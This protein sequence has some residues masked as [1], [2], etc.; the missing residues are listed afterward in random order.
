LSSSHRLFLLSKIA[1]YNE[2][3]YRNLKNLKNSAKTKFSRVTNSQI[4]FI[5][6]CGLAIVKTG[7]GTNKIYKSTF[8]N[9][10]IF[11]K[12]HHSFYI[13]QS[14]DVDAIA[15]LFYMLSKRDRITIIEEVI[16][17]GKLGVSMN[18]LERRMEFPG[19]FSRNIT[20]LT[21]SEIICRKGKKF[22]PGQNMQ[23]AIIILEIL[24]SAITDTSNYLKS[25]VP[26]AKDLF[27]PTQI[28]HSSINATVGYA[29]DYM[30]SRQITHLLFENENGMD[31]AIGK[32]EISESILKGVAK[33]TDRIRKIV[34]DL[35]PIIVAS[36]SKLSINI[37]KKIFQGKVATVIDND[38]KL[39]GVITTNEITNLINFICKFNSHGSGWLTYKPINLIAEKAQVTAIEKSYES[40]NGYDPSFLPGYFIPL[41]TLSKSQKENA[42]MK[43]RVS[44]EDPYELKYQH[45][46]IVMNAKRRM[47]Y[48]AAINIDGSKSIL[49][50]PKPVEFK[51]SAPEIREKWYPD[52]R[53]ELNAQFDKELY[54]NLQHQL[55]DKGQLVPGSYV[56][57]GTP[58]QAKKANVD[59]FHLTNLSLLE[60]FNQVAKIWLGIEDYLLKN[61]GAETMRITVFV[62]PIFKNDD[63]IYRHM[64]IPGLFWKILVQEIEGQLRAIGLMAIHSDRIQTES[65]K[66]SS[67]AVF[68][69]SI[70]ELERIT[71]LDFGSL[72]N[73]DSFQ[74]SFYDNILES[75]S[76]LRHDFS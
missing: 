56:S 68:Q 36:D 51:E 46:S 75:N 73:Y 74:Q 35:D 21:K 37:T 55:V 24:R 23:K 3:D 38:G 53:I 27:V 28:Q 30:T 5:L 40:R 69:V 44:N 39:L 15:D 54:D 70:N 43:T 4:E 34:V 9:N 67:I 65:F 58:E 71:E 76:I 26:S 66:E 59:T 22:V 17:N 13:N 14:I 10:S 7:F 57:W 18:E 61:S 1:D 29:L 47:A 60:G 20:I 52:P 41:P 63:I 42:A 12:L 72:R 8:L 11:D 50:E 19:S 49:V 16:K 48:F 33:P 45:F 31:I 62:G 2:I 6:K 64:K 25:Y 32:I